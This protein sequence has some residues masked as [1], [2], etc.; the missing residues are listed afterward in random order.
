LRG[1]KVLVTIVGYVKSF[2]GEKVF[3]WRVSSLKVPTTVTL[4][5]SYDDGVVLLESI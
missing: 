3:P 2:V 5:D 4:G 1:P